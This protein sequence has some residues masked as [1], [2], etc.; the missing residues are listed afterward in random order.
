MADTILNR[1]IVMAARPSGMPAAE[2]FRLEEVAEPRQPP[3]GEVLLKTLFF[4]LDPY[5]RGRMD[6]GPS[7]AQA[8]E[9]GG[10]MEGGSV[11]EVLAS[12]SADF[13]NSSPTSKASPARAWHAGC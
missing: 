13:R 2:N 1:R 6:A 11:C 3:Q 10:V 12:S 8:L 7:Y 9:P 5:M 4:S